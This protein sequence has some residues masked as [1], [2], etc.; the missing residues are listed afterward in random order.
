ML[1]GADPGCNKEVLNLHN[2]GGDT[3][4]YSGTCGNLCT[5]IFSGLIV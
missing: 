1:S 4:F 3:L 2:G 5:D